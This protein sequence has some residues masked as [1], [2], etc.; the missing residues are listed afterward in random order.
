MFWLLSP[1][2][3]RSGF[4]PATILKPADSSRWKSAEFPVANEAST[5][6]A[7]AASMQS[8]K[9]PRRRPERVNKVA[10]NAASSAIKGTCSWTM[11]AARSI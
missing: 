10:D 11:R 6:S 5:R 3:T 9:E 7:V 1:P 2:G 8:V 4:Q